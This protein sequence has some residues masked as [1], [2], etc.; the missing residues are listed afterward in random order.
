[1]KT[2]E[3]RMCLPVRPVAFKVVL[4]AGL[5]VFSS[6]AIAAT[7]LQKT[8]ASVESS[9]EAR[10]KQRV[11]TFTLE[12][13]GALEPI[14][15]R[16]V[17]GSMA[18]PFSIRSD[19]VVVG[20]KLKV[21]Y[22]YSPSLLDELSHMKVL[23][24][25]ELVAVVPLPRDKGVGNSRDIELDP[26][27]FVDF[28][29]LDFRLI[30]HYTYKCENPVHSS[31][32]L[33][34]SNHGRLELTLAPVV[35]QN[36]LKVLPAPFF[37]SRD[38]S[39]L[40]LPI[41]FSGTPTLG[42]TKAAGIV[43][44]W[45]GS[46]ASYRGARFP[47]LLDAL[48]DG[49]AVVFLQGADHLGGLA[50]ADSPSISIQSHPTT[51]GAK[52]LVVSGRN[53]D[54]LLRAVRAMVLSHGTLSGDKVTVTELSEPP[55]RKPYDAP[56]WIPTDR[57]VSFAE[58][59]R[60]E[61]LQSK[62]FYPA[63]IKVDYRIPPDLFVWRSAGVPMRLKY[64]YSNLG[65]SNTSGLNITA[66]GNFVQALPLDGP[67]WFNSLLGRVRLGDMEGDHAMR[68]AGVVVPPFQV[69]G[70]NQ[71]QF[72]YHF[73]SAQSDEC[74]DAMPDNFSSAINP[75]STIDF[76]GFPHYAALPN[77]ALF[78][79]I[80][81]PFTRL[82]DL[83]ET[84]VVLPDTPNVDE[85]ALYLGLMG[86]MGE[87]T[88]YP[89]LRHAVV[90]ASGVDSVA[91]RD[92]MVI[93]SDQRQPLMTRWAD[94]LPL[95]QVN[96]ERQVREPDFFKRASFLWGERNEQSPGNRV[97]AFR[98]KGGS[99]LVTLMGFES[100]LRSGRSVV[101]FH[102]DQSKELALISETLNDPA[103]R[104]EIQG[105]FVVIGGANITHSTIADAYYIGSLR[106]TTYLRWVLS[107]HP[108]LSAGVG[109]L[110]C[111]LLATLAYRALRGV[112]ARRI[113]ASL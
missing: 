4:V 107:S 81:F 34:L 32:W 105:D 95:V 33:N 49:N 71:L 41:V 42:A 112:A 93:G 2:L 96:G 111:L 37:D 76:R 21:S 72:Q 43:A 30:G 5:A 27:L 65:F 109:L 62:G 79:D 52:L 110:I 113:K 35:L 36:D 89:V 20:A 77:L 28:N 85:L 80:G 70:R 67:G 14:Q 75:E 44:S 87:A 18:L 91:D 48:P 31:L 50:A 47:V 103:H 88:G 68:E 64:R 104:D 22:D 17:D 15:L 86:R 1:M 83:S 40:T 16:G 9:Q 82:A 6:Y 10:P 69:S 101:Y 59:V 24:N 11:V 45:F 94:W 102:A 98:V 13:M 46:L 73:E 99:G 23:L 53:E 108:L 78:S 39:E 8:T 29:S 26:R 92:L 97:G 84:A 74:R 19:E 7:P 100:P 60:V 54:D 106:W 56:A 63:V 61:D 51:P 90:L 57:P 58:L 3:V 38:S 66:N 12:E 55:V 25:E